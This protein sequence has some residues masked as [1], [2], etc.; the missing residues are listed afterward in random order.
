MDHVK[1][2]ISVRVIWVYGCMDVSWVRWVGEVGSV[3]YS[4]LVA[5]EQSNDAAMLST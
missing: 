2:G 5:L 1:Y 3:F 4:R